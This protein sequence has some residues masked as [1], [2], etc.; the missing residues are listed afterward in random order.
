VSSKLPTKGGA[1]RLFIKGA[2]LIAGAVRGDGGTW[3]KIVNASKWFFVA[4]SGVSAYD[5]WN[6]DSLG[7]EQGTAS[8]QQGIQ[9]NSTASESALP[10]V[11]GLAKVGLKI[12]DVRQVD[13][14]EYK[15]MSVTGAY[16][17]GSGGGNATAERGISGVGKVYFD[18]TLAI[19][20][21]EE[22]A[23]SGAGNPTKTNV[24]QTQF[25]NGSSV[26]WGTAWFLR[27]MIHT[28][29]QTAVDYYLNNQHSY[30]TTAG[31][32]WG[33]QTIGQGIAYA[34]FWVFYDTDAY[35]NGLPNITMEMS[36]NKVP[37]VTNLTLAQAYSTNP[38]NCIYDFMT[39]KT[40]GMGIPGY[41]IDTASF[42]VARAFCD[43]SVSFTLASGSGYT[44]TRYRCDGIL[45][46]G[47]SP[48]ANIQK[49]LTC[50][51]G[52][53]V[54]EN[55]MYTLKLRKVTSAE[56]FQLDE[57]NIVGD[58]SFRRAGID[59]TCNSITVTYIDKLQN[60]QPQSLTWPYPGDANPYLVEDSGFLNELAVELPF[61]NHEYRAALMAS[62]IL[63]E[64]RADMTCT[65]TA[66]REA[67]KLTVG[68]VV[69]V[70]HSTPDWDEQLMWVEAVSLRGDGLVSLAL[71]E[72]VA[73]TYT[74]PIIQNLVAIVANNLPAQYSSGTGI[75]PGEGPL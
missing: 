43:E 4:R 37:N 10:I 11:Y 23:N 14:A 20:G 67:L 38:A 28:G 69:K 34:T 53:I 57:T 60:Y 47:E 2:A 46:S 31:G 59:D 45:N 15:T 74:P 32:A 33:T 42:E 51:N 71:K 40:Y 49:L 64:T 7:K 66:Q 39:S 27:Y 55:G 50:C 1:F 6:Q 61:T 52:R 25:W 12:I 8:K 24:V 36:G 19:N 41:D 3:V 75:L 62:Q 9:V 44:F 48:M 22:S 13:A 26:A 18:E 54:Y 58:L 73:A 5:A 21:A 30:Y 63:L 68:S 16:A 70:S 29:N 17:I 65:L 72:Y 56:T 35:P